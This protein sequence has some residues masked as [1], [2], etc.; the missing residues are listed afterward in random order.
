MA[1]RRKADVSELVAEFYYH[2]TNRKY[3]DEQVGK[4]GVY[5]HKNPWHGDW[6]VF[7]GDNR[8][9]SEWYACDRCAVPSWEPILLVIPGDNIRDR[10]YTHPVMN[11]ICVN[12]LKPGEY[13]II[14]L[15]EQTRTD[16]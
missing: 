10:I 7:V 9:N 1:G 6:R 14:S 8:A 13:D 4:H 5:N 3:Y 16:R 15:V 12:F 11:D 2:G